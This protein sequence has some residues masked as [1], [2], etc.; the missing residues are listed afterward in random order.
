MGDFGEEMVINKNKGE[1]RM[2]LSVV[3]VSYNTKDLLSNCLKSIFE[4]TKDI[5]FEVWVVDNNSPDGSADMV[6]AEFPHMTKVL[7]PPHIEIL[8]YFALFVN[9][10]MAIV[11]FIL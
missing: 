7:E 2:E 6:E 11:Y 8:I 3:I 9:Q 1:V 4:Q 10:N 5:C